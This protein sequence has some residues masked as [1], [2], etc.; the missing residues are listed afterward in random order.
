MAPRLT[1]AA[2]LEGVQAGVNWP[3]DILRAGALGRDFA[4]SLGFPTLHCDEISLVVTE[5]AANLI[6]H[7]SGGTIGLEHVM[8]GE[9]P[10]IEVRSVDNGPGISNVDQAITD[11]YSTAGGLGL[12]LGTVNRLMDELEIYSGSE[13]GLNVACRR[14]RRAQPSAMTLGGL[15]F[16]AA[17]RACRQLRE[18]GDAFIFKRWE[19]YALIGV[20]DGLGH[21]QFAQRASETARQYIERHFD[22]TLENL[23]RGAGRACRATRGVVMAL[24]RFDLLRRTVTVAGVGNIEV[25]LVGGPERFKLVVRR[26]IVGLNAPD[27]VPTVHPWTSTSLL[28]MH[29]DGIHTRWDW[30]EFSDVMR[31]TPN[32]IAQRLLAKLGTLDDD[33]TVIVARGVD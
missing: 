20:F 2:K 8:P 18:N 15:A 33:A 22:Q 32:V 25:R 5:L 30:S 24:A 29:S 9:R 23:F 7:A 4:A 16:D 12:G 17:T 19:Q 28:I 1:G 3:G 26:G 11:G 21:G 10:G 6:R 27:P 31:H 13:G 14:W